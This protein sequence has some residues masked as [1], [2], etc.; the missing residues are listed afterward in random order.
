[1]ED[2]GRFNLGKSARGQGE[3]RPWKD[4]VACR[5]ALTAGREGIETGVVHIGNGTPR[6]AVGVVRASHGSGERGEC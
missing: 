1:M 5:V 2:G 3:Q 6:A 4:A